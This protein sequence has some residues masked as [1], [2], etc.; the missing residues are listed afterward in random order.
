M[1]WVNTNLRPSIGVTA[2]HGYQKYCTKFL[3]RKKCNRIKCQLL[4]E[5]K[6]FKEVLN[7]ER[8]QQL[9]PL[10]RKPGLRPIFPEQGQCGKLLTLST[11]IPRYKCI[12]IFESNEIR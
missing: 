2:K 9:N 12:C 10:N 7:Q 8:V 4:H 1:F 11:Y 6:D 3:Q 5:W